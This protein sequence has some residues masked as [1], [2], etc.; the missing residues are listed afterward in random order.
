M[1]Q[2]LAKC[3]KTH[4]DEY[5]MVEYVEGDKESC[6]VKIYHKGRKYYVNEKYHDPEFFEVIKPAV[7]VV[8]NSLPVRYCQQCGEPLRRDKHKTWCE[9]Y[10]Q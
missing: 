4:P 8:S 2:V 3:L 6:D 1:E 7:P 10:K 5:G 9:H